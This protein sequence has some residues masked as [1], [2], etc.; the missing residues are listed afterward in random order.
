MAKVDVWRSEVL[1]VCVKVE[2]SHGRVVSHRRKG[3]IS[4]FEVV[5]LPG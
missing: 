1:D 4:D 2:L 5:Y 3:V